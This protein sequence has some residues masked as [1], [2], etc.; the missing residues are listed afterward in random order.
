[1]SRIVSMYC[2]TCNQQVA[3]TAPRANHVL[4]L[5]ISV[6]LCGFWVPVWLLC[7]LF[8]GAARCNVCGSMSLANKLVNNVIN[9][10]AAAMILFFI[11]GVYSVMSESNPGS[12]P[13]T[14]ILTQTPS[15]TPRPAQ[16]PAS[17]DPAPSPTSEPETTPDPDPA[18]S[19]SPDSATIVEQLKE[20]ETQLSDLQSQDANTLV[21][22]SSRFEWSGDFIKSPILEIGV[23]NDGPHA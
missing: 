13:N 21:V 22:V 8:P 1:M 2:S 5:L 6:L 11:F 3:A 23:K 20:L 19:R 16:Q 9:L 15:S 14:T 7:A 18:E 17:T 12:R 10:T 4:H